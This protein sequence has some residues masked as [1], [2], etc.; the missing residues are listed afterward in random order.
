MNIHDLY[1][2]GISKTSTRLLMNPLRRVLFKLMRPYFDRLIE[3]INKLESPKAKTIE[4]RLQAVE[5]DREAMAHRF[6]TIESKLRY[7]K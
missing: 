4:T 1:Q 3:E 6:N 2:V 7:K 5:K